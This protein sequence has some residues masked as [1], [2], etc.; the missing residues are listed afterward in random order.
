MTFS[1]A[2]GSLA[3]SVVL[4]KNSSPALTSA[5]R[6]GRRSRHDGR[7]IAGVNSHSCVAISA[8][9]EGAM[10]SRGRQGRV[11]GNPGP[12]FRVGTTDIYA[13]DSPVQTGGPT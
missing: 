1:S 10:R 2:R 12:R 3:Q 13:L 8:G 6:G 11:R 5:S 4:Y 9:M 7:A